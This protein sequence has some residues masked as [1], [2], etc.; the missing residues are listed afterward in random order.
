MKRGLFVLSLVLVLA[1]AFPLPALASEFPDGRVVFG[2]TFTLESGDVLDGDLAV[3]GGVVTLE[4]GSRVAGDVAVFG[5]TLEANGVIEGD[6]VTMGGLVELGPTAVVEGDLVYFGSQVDKAPGAQ[7]LGQEVTG[8]GF[9]VPFN[10]GDFAIPQVES[11]PFRVG[12]FWSLVVSPIVQVLWL[13]FRTLVMAALAVLVVLFWPE[14]TARTA[15]AAVAQPLAAGGLGFLTFIAVPVILVVLLLTILLSPI[16]LLGFA[17]L[18]VA[19]VF[20]WI[21][22]G[23][24]V[25]RRL[26]EALKWEA[27]PAAAAGAGTLVLS[28]VAGGLGFIPCIGWL[29][30]FL[31]ACVGLGAVL[32]TRF[33][34]QTY[35]PVAAEA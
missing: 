26:A 7:V 27:H 10:F 31:A 33:G 2:G 17:L 21:A 15:E 8:E 35:P 24:E 18:V 29:A 12:N 5:G 6:L 19:A 34:T 9:D 13:G 11:F 22:L 3:F 28:L 16:S 4:E 32:L 25:G 14:P 30:P 20:G 1:L 23:Y